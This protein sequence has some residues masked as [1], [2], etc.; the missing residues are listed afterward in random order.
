MTF[1]VDEITFLK[2]E[3]MTKVNMFEMAKEIGATNGYLL[4]RPIGELANIYISKEL[5][6]LSERH[7]LFLD[8]ANIPI[9]DVSF[10]DEAII[11]LLEEILE[12][13]YGHRRIIFQNLNEDSI[14]NFNAAVKLRNLKMALFAI[15]AEDKWR[16]LGHL[17][18]SLKQVF[19]MIMKRGSITAPHLAK[20][21]DIALNA[22][23]NR[24]KRLLVQRLIRREYEEKEGGLV[25]IYRKWDWT[26]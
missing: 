24:L 15:N 19:D 16:L 25:Y 18:K 13:K 3:N 12:D 8:F 5:G 22:A 4:T 17:E 21:L 14:T 7:S 11:L 26:E 20:D 1:F 6:S 9:V 23:N 10:F 2:S